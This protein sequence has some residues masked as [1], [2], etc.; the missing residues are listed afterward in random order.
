[1]AD[2]VIQTLV[3]VVHFKSPFTVFKLIISHSIWRNRIAHIGQSEYLQSEVPR[4]K[5]LNDFIFAFLRYKEAA[6]P[7][8][9]W[10]EQSLNSFRESLLDLCQPNRVPAH[11]PLERS[12]PQNPGSPSNDSHFG[13]PKS[14]AAQAASTKQILDNFNKLMSACVVLRIENFMLYRVTTSGKKQM[15]KEFISGMHFHT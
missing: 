9:L 3:M 14:N 11:A 1:M 5:G 10:L 12:S 8:A 15:P 7:P 6:V 4:R 2:H 13:S